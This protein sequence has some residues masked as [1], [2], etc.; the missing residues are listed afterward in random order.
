MRGRPWSPLLGAL[1]RA[2]LLAGLLAGCALL[3]EMHGGGPDSSTA[4]STDGG[5]G[6]PATSATEP[7]AIPD[8][9]HPLEHRAGE[10]VDIGD[11]TIVFMGMADGGSV[12]RFRVTEGTWPDEA[13]LIGGDGGMVSLV[14]DGEIVESQPFADPPTQLTLLVGESLFVFAT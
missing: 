12:A 3:E 5:A 6:E 11:A 1:L 13:R 4:P 9:L 10:A 8:P 14:L 7:V 2:S